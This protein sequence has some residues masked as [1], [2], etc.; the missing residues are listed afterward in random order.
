M[1]LDANNQEIT[2]DAA[3]IQADAAK[4][5]SVID[6]IKAQVAVLQ[7]NLATETALEVTDQTTI[8]ALEAQ[9]AVLQ[10]ELAALQPPP[11][12]PPKATLANAMLNLEA[13]TDWIQDGNS[14]DSGG[15]SGKKNG[16]F[17]MTPGTPALF[18]AKGNYPWNNGY[19]Y[20]K[21]YGYP[22]NKATKFRLALEMQLPSIADLG[23]CNCLEF[24]CQQAA[25]GWIYNF[26][27]QANTGERLWTYFDF[28]NRK[29]IPSKIPLTL[30]AQK[31]MSVVANFAIPKP[32]T[33][34]HT[35]LTVDDKVYPC[36][37]SLPAA[38]GGSADY[39]SHA[40]QLDSNGK[41]P[42]SPYSALVRNYHLSWE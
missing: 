42:P 3:Q 13:K 23:A 30:G 17:T 22:S 24:E 11:P 9:I 21:L 15:S 6:G 1:T 19:W 7:T 10:T 8:A 4:E 34:V 25:A 35:D 12:V 2:N 18:S 41:N 5:Q 31:W 16:I 36:N 26:A 28:V 38:P 20:R 39:L 32:G 14:G 37:V 33:A 29:W 27:W 40:F